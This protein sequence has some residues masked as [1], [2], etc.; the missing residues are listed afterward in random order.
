MGR[1]SRSTNTSLNWLCE[2]AF[3]ILNDCRLSTLAPKRLNKSPSSRI[4]ANRIT[5][6]TGLSKILSSGSIRSMGAK[7]KRSRREQTDLHAILI[8][9]ADRSSEIHMDH[10]LLTHRCKPAT[11]KGFRGL[12]KRLNFLTYLPEISY[13]SFL[14]TSL[15]FF[16]KDTY[17]FSGRYRGDFCDR[18]AGGIIST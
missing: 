18:V 12:H 9:N 6:V 13:L 3:T 17:H 14:K 16:R 1:F 5:S 15:K 4:T 10:L 2:K 11:G 8:R 7:I